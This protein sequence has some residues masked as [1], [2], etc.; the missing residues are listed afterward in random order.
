MEEIK[1]KG[2]RSAGS[3]R[4]DGKSISRQS[5]TERASDGK[6][7]RSRSSDGTGGRSVRRSGSAGR[8]S[9]GQR[10]ADGGK[11]RSRR[12]DGGKNAS[13]R[14]TDGKSIS[15]RGADGKSI[16]QRGADGKSIHH[17]RPPRE[18]EGGGGETRPGGR[19]GGRR[20]KK[21]QKN[22]L[23][24]NIILVVAI[25]VFCVSAFQL[26]RIG[27]GYYDG[28]SE[29]E[30]IRELAISEDK[31]DG[32][33]F[34]VNFDELRALNPDTIAWLRFDPEPKVIN[35]P[36]VQGKDNDEY[37]HKTFSANENTLGTIFLNV[38]NNENFLD[39]NSILYGHYM[40]D[41][42]MFRHLE[43]YKDKAFWEANPYFYIYTPDGQELVY[44]IYSVG[45]VLDTSD[46][47]LTDFPTNDDYQKFLN[48]TK[49]VAMYDTG[50]E[51]TTG[52]TIV[53][54]STCT[55]ANNDHRFVVRGVKVRE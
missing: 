34:Q 50:I 14:S 40:N 18:E 24:T 16:S 4:P 38:D 46:T 15:Q 23:L 19:R 1:N 35:Y 27:K 2:S 45:E 44:H 5:G 8:E 6:S 39:E 21:K 53:T 9:A 36:V 42:S 49:E 29:Y 33:R 48:M 47:Y 51:V 3:R 55:S 26:F 54:L 31:K 28:R 13:Q 11:I 32:S 25:A 52:D 37:L 17:R 30:K 22:S 20:R 10:D 7:I 43:D 12:P 41:G